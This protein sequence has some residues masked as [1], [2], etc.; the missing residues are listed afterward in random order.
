MQVSPRVDVSLRFLPRGEHDQVLPW[1]EDGLREARKRPFVEIGRIVG[2]VPAGKVDSG[3]GRIMNLD[4]IGRIAVAV[5]EHV[6]VRRQKL[7]NDRLCV[8]QKPRL[9]RL[10]A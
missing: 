7:R 10:V 8:E 2:E 9:E 4:P 3:S 1:I 5:V 6:V